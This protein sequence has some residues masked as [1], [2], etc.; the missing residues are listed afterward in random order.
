MKTLSNG[1]PSNQQ[2]YLRDAGAI[3][4]VSMH[5]LEDFINPS[6]SRKSA[7]EHSSHSTQSQQQLML[8]RLSQMQKLPES[9]DDDIEEIG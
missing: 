7:L 4:G 9:I 5:E 3:L 8:H 6:P 1:S 2:L